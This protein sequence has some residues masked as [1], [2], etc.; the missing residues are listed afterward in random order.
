MQLVKWRNKKYPGNLHQIKK[1]KK[2]A[3]DTFLYQN[4]HLKIIVSIIN[5][6]SN[7]AWL[8][9]VLVVINNNLLHLYSAFLGTQSTLH[10]KGIHLL[11]NTIKLEL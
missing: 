6:L 11:R 2:T 8:H 10:R 9:S 3:K 5:I 7:R 4:I 1:L